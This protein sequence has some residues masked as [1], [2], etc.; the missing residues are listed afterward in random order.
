MPL[1][2]KTTWQLRNMRDVERAL[3]LSDQSTPLRLSRPERLFF[4]EIRDGANKNKAVTG[5]KTWDRRKGESF[6]HIWKFHSR[7]TGWLVSCHRILENID[8]FLFSSQW[9]TFK[10]SEPFA[11]RELYSV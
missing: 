9:E 4:F 6:G 5:G 1:E 2:L 11:W 7:E 3:G 10:G 8:S